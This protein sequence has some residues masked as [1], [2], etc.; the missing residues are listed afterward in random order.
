MNLQDWMGPVE[1]H[2]KQ[3]GIQ[4]PVK[5]FVIGTSPFCMPA[6]TRVCAARLE[7]P[8]TCSNTALLAT[9]S[10]LGRTRTPTTRALA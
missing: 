6:H 4:T 8:L 2:L 1:C 5:Y 10:W 7:G 3:A 9:L